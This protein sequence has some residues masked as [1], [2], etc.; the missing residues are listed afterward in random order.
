MRIDPYHNRRRYEAWKK[1][2]ASGIRGLSRENAELVRAY[3]E[4][5]EHGRN[6]AKG[7][8]KGGRSHIHLNNI[9]QRMVFISRKLEE[10]YPGILLSE[11]QEEQ[12][13]GLFADLRSGELRKTNGDAYKAP[14]NYV[15]AFKAFWHWH[16]KR[17]KKQG[18]LVEDI[19]EDLDDSRPKPKWVY[20][21]HKEVEKLCRH[22]KFRY[23]VLMTFLFDTGI[24]SPTELVNVRVGDLSSD[25]GQLRI[26]LEASKTFE[27]TIN[28]LLSPSLLKE[29]VESEGLSG[30]AQLFSIT[31]AVV[32]R[33][34]K[35]LALRVLGG[36][37]S[38]AGR[39]YSRLTMYDF[40]HSSACYWRPR[41][42]SDSALMYRFG[43]TRP[44]MIKY[45]TEFLGMRD[46]ITEEDLL[47][48]GEKTAVERRAEKAEA[49]KKILEERLERMQEQMR[50][51]HSV[52]R[53]MKAGV[54]PD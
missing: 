32:N 13:H 8:K 20:L 47:L 2:T 3:V 14:G 18:C 43:W 21:T 54:M 12:V 16:I 23:Q 36:G 46:T 51:I 39:R 11:V 38:P 19:C 50:E 35:R 53:E 37:L 30:E 40:R 29:H 7:T 34:F 52:V 49:E 45:Y 31:P 48:P 24:R 28:L 33:Y 10:R 9:R 42:K 4:D 27:R 6:I 15:K 25:Y 17:E 26:R 44:E 22:A 41:Y 1:R 5:M